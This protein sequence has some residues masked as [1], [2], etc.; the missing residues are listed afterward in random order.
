[1]TIKLD[2][3]GLVPAV[4]QDINTKAVLMVGY[5]NPGSLKRTLESG[6]VWFYSRSREELWH[7]GET[8]GNLMNLK[9]AWVDCDS[10]TLLLQ[11]EPEGPACHTGNVSCFFTPLDAKPEYQEAERGSGVLEEL[12][13]VIK[14]RQ[15]DMPQGSYTAELLKA[16]VG[17]VAQKV[18]EEAGESAI[19]AV[20][21]SERVPQEVADL[22]YHA[23]VLLAASGVSP[24]AVW[25]ELRTRRK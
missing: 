9:A 23:L 6:H 17:R 14:E 7:K 1:M 18:I 24:E 5:V 8:S 20:E 12:F 11:V 13:A 4:V 15:Q 19:A 3:Q 16:G 2:Q 22:F 21:G 25:Q 10:D